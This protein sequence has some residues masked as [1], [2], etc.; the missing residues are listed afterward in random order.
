MRL[1][2]DRAPLQTGSFHLT[3]KEK[4]GTGMP[5]AGDK[6]VFWATLARPLT[7]ALG[8]GVC[9]TCGLAA[10]QRLAPLSA[11]SLFPFAETWYAKSAAATTPA[12]GVADAQK[13][14]ELAPTHAE[15]WMLLAY[16]YSLADHDVSPR[17][18]AA[19]RQSYAVS[20]LDQDVSAYRLSF[21]FNVWPKLPDDVRDLA[22]EE[23]RQFGVTGT[24]LTFMRQAV[25]TIRDD[26]ARFE[27]AVIT[28]MDHVQADEMSDKQQKH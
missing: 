5:K 20:P 25:P 28:M 26:R 27:F 6:Q 2:R 7:V 17:V 23:A 12:V 18:I 14:I 1:F 19:V 8:F 3:I 13:V 24:G 4:G 11:P 9:V 22:R 21:I 15:N 16:Q 10:W